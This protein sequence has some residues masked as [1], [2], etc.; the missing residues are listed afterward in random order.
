[1][2]IDQFLAEMTGELAALDDVVGDLERVEIAERKAGAIKFTAP[3]AG[4]RWQVVPLIDML[5]E[6]VLHIGCL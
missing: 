2:F 3:E 1:M 4:R 6:A 5:K